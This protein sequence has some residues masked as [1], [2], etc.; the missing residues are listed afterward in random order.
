MKIHTLEQTQDFPITMEEAWDFFSDPRN[1][2]EITSDDVGFEILNISGG[3]MHPGQIISYRI[4]VPPGIPVT[5]VTEIT[6]VDEGKSFIDDQ[7]FGPYKFWHH[8]HSFEEIPGGV[9]M[10]DL[11]HYALPFSPFGE[12]GHGIF[13][14]PKLTQIFES[15]RA[16]LTEKFGIL[17]KS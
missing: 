9:R 4:K 13:V 16:T 5:W 17:E 11:V 2:D 1:L 7:R 8:K 10:H 6:H 14:K 15:R 12:I 3:K